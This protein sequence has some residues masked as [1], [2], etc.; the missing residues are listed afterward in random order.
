MLSPRLIAL[1]FF[2]MVCAAADSP[3]AGPVGAPPGVVEVWSFKRPRAYALDL[4]KV[5]VLDPRGDIGAA[6]GPSV[7]PH[8]YPGW[9]VI[10]LPAERRTEQGVRAAVADPTA[11]LGAGVPPDLAAS[12]FA[13]PILLDDLGGPMVVRPSVL[14]RFESDVPGGEAEKRLLSRPGVRVAERRFGGLPN[15]F[16]VEPDGLDG[17]GIIGLAAELAQDPL[18]RFAE[19]DMV[20]SGRSSLI[21]NDPGFSACW[22]LL[23]NGSGG[24]LLDFDMDATDAWDLTTG[25]P[26]V[27]VVV[28]DTGIQ[29]DHPDINQIPG[30][31]FTGGGTGGGPGNPCEAHGTAVAGCVSA[32]INNGVGVV[33]VAPG[34]KVASARPFVANTTVCDG[35]WLGGSSETVAALN[36][37]QAIGAR[38]TNNSNYYGF[39]SSA[40]ADTYAATRAAGIV[41]FASAGNFSASGVTYPSSL[42]SVNAVAAMARNG[43]R[44]GFSNWGP[45]LDFSAP[46]VAILT[47]D[48]TGNAGYSSGDLVS[49]DGTSF[50]SPYS[51]GVAALVISYIPNLTAFQVEG[52]MQSGCTELGQPGYDTEF[53]WGMV[54]AYRSMT[55][56]PPPPPPPPGAFDLLSPVSGATGVAL[57]TLLSWS[58]SSGAVS[59]LFTLDNDA[60][61][62][63]P[64]VS[65]STPGLSVSASPG[66]LSAG[67]TYHW[68]VTALNIE[69]AATASTPPSAAFTTVPPIIPCSGDLTNDGRV[70]TVDLAVFLGL[71]G[72]AVPPGSAGDSNG[73]GVVNT[74]DLTR[75]LGDFGRTDC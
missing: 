2:G 25:D 66:L 51:A 12:L 24:G 37:A 6:G 48:R 59:Y 69:G 5:A 27:V 33:G 63:S 71:F 1:G 19:P 3:A 4:T 29:Q 26:S 28:L 50:A 42:P 62:S 45:G 40:I 11:L 58:A 7:T 65:V 21:P 22:G 36:W 39:T 55:G 34:C 17:F 54:N 14:V 31:D 20:F 10:A 53:G 61:F 44:A 68:K 32:I 43:T 74:I 60:D 35:S 67:Q 8:G 9:S 15:S 46:G 18:V 47:T 56:S 23:N 57:N 38:V 30:A 16:R 13:S 73:D 64:L 49:I 52:L 70:D 75:F 41:H 72:R